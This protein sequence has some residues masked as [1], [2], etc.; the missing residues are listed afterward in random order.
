M[1]WRGTFVNQSRDCWGSLYCLQWSWRSATM[2]G[3]TLSNSFS[4][5]GMVL[6]GKSK[7]KRCRYGSRAEQSRGACAR[8]GSSQVG[9]FRGE[10]AVVLPGGRGEGARGVM[11]GRACVS[12]CLVAPACR[13]VWSRLPPLLRA[14]VLG[15]GTT[16]DRAADAHQTP[17][18][19]RR[20]DVTGLERLTEHR[21][22][23]A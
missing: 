10:R 18:D 1:G 12:C 4:V 9:N 22:I 5:V 13:V 17:D 21:S 16:R 15:P 7:S 6:L 2:R 20:L 8:A 11:F 19:A 23:G 3:Q 14:R